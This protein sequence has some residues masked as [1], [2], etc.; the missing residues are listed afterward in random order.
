ME[1][2]ARTKSELLD[3]L[4]ATLAPVPPG[5]TKVA[6]GETPSL[7]GHWPRPSTLCGKDAAWDTRLPVET[8]RCRDCQAARRI[9][10]T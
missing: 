8:A 5:T 6:F 10:R 3:D 7:S 4:E 2:Q 1:V 9:P